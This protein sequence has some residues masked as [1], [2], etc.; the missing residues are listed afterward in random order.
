MRFVRVDGTN[1]E[2]DPETSNSLMPK[3][4]P[5]FP[6]RVIPPR[7]PPIAVSESVSIAARSN[8]LPSFAARSP[9][10]NLDA[11]HY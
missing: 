4:R 9:R 8:V 5:S 10:H 2:S 3:Q 7:N 6:L 11:V 1:P